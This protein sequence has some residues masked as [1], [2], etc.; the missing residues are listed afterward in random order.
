MAA[1]ASPANWR[2]LT[3][4]LIYPNPAGSQTSL[5]LATEVAGTACIQLLNAQGITVTEQKWQLRQ[6]FN[7]RLLELNL[8]KGVY[9]VVINGH[10][11]TI[12]TTARR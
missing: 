8:A 3:G 10:R 12:Y 7:T 5:N 9:M 6:G 1:P 2:R 11:Q 4:L